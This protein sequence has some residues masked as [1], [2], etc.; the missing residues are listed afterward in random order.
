MCMCDRLNDDDSS[1]CNFKAATASLYIS[2]T[3]ADYSSSSRVL[4]QRDVAM[5]E[6]NRTLYL[7]CE[8]IS[9]KPQHQSF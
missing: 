8:P 6:L 9:C 3:I 1:S 5:Y 2:F 7:G 4:M